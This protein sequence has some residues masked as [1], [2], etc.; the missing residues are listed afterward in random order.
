MYIS[1]ELESSLLESLV[2]LVKELDLAVSRDKL[3]VLCVSPDYSSIV[4]LRVLHALS[5]DG[6]LPQYVFLDVAYPDDSE[7]KKAQY[8]KVVEIM[9]PHFKKTVDKIILVE[10]AVLTGKNYKWI[11]EELVKV[12]FKEEDVITV[13][14]LETK[15]SIFKSDIVAQYVEGIPEFYWEEYNKH[16]E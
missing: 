12:G 5:K 2:G 11:K 13:A 15:D 6:E 3:A 4:G 1:K 9:A 16:W 7:E 8:K 10:A 14:L